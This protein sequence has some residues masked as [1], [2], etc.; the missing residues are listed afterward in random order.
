M[1]VVGR[2]KLL[3][4]KYDLPS[5]RD[6]FNN[7]PSRDAWKKM[8]DSRVTEY[9]LNLIYQTQ[10]SAYPSLKLNTEVCTLKDPHPLITMMSNSPRDVARSSVK[11]RLL[12]GTYA[13]QST[14]KAFNQTIRILR[15]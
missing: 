1:T 12:T 13:L 14:R 10:S 11:W 15:V 5:A 9:W 6:I 3:L 2:I 7:P 8:V 4:S